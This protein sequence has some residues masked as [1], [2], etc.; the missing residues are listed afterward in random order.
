MRLIRIS[1]VTDPELTDYTQLTDV[2]LR[3]VREP[4]EGLYLAESPKV[5]ERALRTGHRPRSLLLLE[6]G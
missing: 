1:D 5:I 3:R 2:A 4:E 6:G